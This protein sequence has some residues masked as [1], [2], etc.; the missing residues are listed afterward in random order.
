VFDGEPRLDP[1]YLRLTN[2]YILPH[3]G[4]ASIEAR[5]AMGFCCIDNLQAV[6]IDGKP[7]PT[8]VKP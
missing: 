3:M 5:N 4:S 2:A 8:L 6:L 7:A 1:R